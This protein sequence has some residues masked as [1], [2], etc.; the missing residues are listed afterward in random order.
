MRLGA[1]VSGGP[2][3]VACPRELRTRHDEADITAGVG[4][5][6]LLGWRRK[7]KAALA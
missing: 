4:L 3:F 5:L 2:H 7:R 6:G 1:D